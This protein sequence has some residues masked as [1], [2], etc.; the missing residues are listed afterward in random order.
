MKRLFAAVI[1]TFMLATMGDALAGAIKS[2]A[3]GEYLLS[4]DLNANFNHIHNTMVGGHGARLMN[5]DVSASAAIAHTKMASP[6][7]LPKAVAIVG[8]QVGGGTACTSG[9][10]SLGFMQP[11]SFF[12]VAHTATGK[13]TVTM[14]ARANAVYVP[15]VTT[16][17]STDTAVVCEPV[18][19]TTTT[20]EVW[21][22][23]A[24]DASD[25]DTV[26][27]ITFYDNDN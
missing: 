26:F 14:S 9:T 13:Y 25:L 2:W 3:S 24:A 4:G 5:A 7:L 6:A 10:C 23:V 19:F 20:F 16:F 21:C 15:V 8:S 12:S 22:E 18:T 17:H 27:M 1:L 11:A